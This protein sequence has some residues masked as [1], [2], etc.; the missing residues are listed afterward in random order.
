M[1]N[2]VDKNGKTLRIRD[3]VYC[4]LEDGTM[5][6]GRILYHKDEKQYLVLFKYSMWYGE[7]E[8]D[9]HSYGKGYV[10]KDVEPED[11]ELIESYIGGR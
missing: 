2:F 8:F 7:D 4:R 1:P 9:Y 6:E 5:A 3:K 10:L 11:L